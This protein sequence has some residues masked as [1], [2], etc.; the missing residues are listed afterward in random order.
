MEYLMKNTINLENCCFN[1][2][3]LRMLKKNIKLGFEVVIWW[4]R[5]NMKEKK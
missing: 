5:F 2:T 4:G 1:P 3:E